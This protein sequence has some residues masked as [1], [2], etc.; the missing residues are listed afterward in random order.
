MVRKGPTS[1]LS[2]L[3]RVPQSIHPTRYAFDSEQGVGRRAATAQLSMRWVEIIDGGRKNWGA[4]EES[5]SRGVEEQGEED[6]KGTQSDI[7]V[8]F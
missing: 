2:L 3:H 5:R 6:S 7:N 1:S 4:V 8:R